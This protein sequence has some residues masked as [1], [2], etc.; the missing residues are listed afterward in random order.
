MY[1]TYHYPASS[2]KSCAV[3]TTFSTL[4]SFLGDFLEL[5]LAR[6]SMCGVIGGAQA[7]FEPRPGC[8]MQAEKESF[9]PLTSGL[10]CQ[11]MECYLPQELQED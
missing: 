8:V 3:N 9:N 1:F 11:G 5:H 7:A 6:V 2:S 10:P 4:F